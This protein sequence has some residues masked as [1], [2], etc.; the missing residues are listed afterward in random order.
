VNGAICHDG[1]CTFEL[2]APLLERVEIEIIGARERRIAMV[3]NPRGCHWAVVDGV[4]PG[5]RYV[6]RAGDRRFADPAARFQPEGVH[7][8]SEVVA[9]TFEWTDAAW[10]GRP[11]SDAVIYELH[12]GTFT[13]GGTFDDAIAELERLRALGVNAIEVMPVAQCPGSR[14]WGYDGVFPFA[15]AAAYGG[16]DG[17]RRFVDACHARGLAVILDVVYNHFG[18]EGAVFDGLAPYYNRDLQTPWGAAIN[19]DGP[20]SDG[21][22]RFF[23][24]NARMWLADFHVDGLRLD[25]VHGIV[26][27]S[28]RK[29][30]AELAEEAAELAASS[31]RRWLIAESD[32]ND[33]AIVRP[34]ELGGLGLDAVWADDF[35]HALHCL[36]TGE[37]DGY[38]ADYVEPGM[39]VRAIEHG[40]AYTGEYSAFRDR[41]HGAPTHGLPP[42][43]F[44]V[45]AQNHDQ[46][47]NRLRGDRLTS[48][49][50]P[51]AARLALALL[52]L[53]P[54]VPLL[55]MGE[56]YGETR[57]FL[58]FTDHGDPAL[59]EAVRRGRQEEFAAF[60]WAEE[61]A[62]PQDPETM[63]RCV[64][65]RDPSDEV[66]ARERLCH[67]LL[68]LRRRPSFAE[69]R[70]STTAE[71]VADDRVLVVRYGERAQLSAVFV[72]EELEGAIDLGADSRLLMEA[73][74]PRYGG[75]RRVLPEGFTGA[76][77]RSVPR[78]WFAVFERT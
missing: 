47:G 9:S 39:L 53:S 52:L 66:I 24:D 43:A 3:R 60:G 59:V 13:P 33:P 68:A 64:L 32:A 56:E 50:A 78:F 42:A 72:L 73:G 7:G 57:P 27:R 70:V 19:F 69:H 12:V 28:P 40:F 36:L 2:W 74:D 16:P 76:A 71:L 30:L 15:V 49:V 67:D 58:Y 23:L 10:C 75:R 35:H 14:N 54:H 77:I 4:G 31:W 41:R 37:R 34:P 22:R 29:F 63:T 45:C 46:I 55:F 20:G 38:Y 18:P 65:R 6:F 17:L 48:L 5:T 21:V 44:V 8:P 1:S 26:D 11:W 25:A 51:D 61:P 62:D